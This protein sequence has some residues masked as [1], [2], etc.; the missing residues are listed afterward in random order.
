MSATVNN[1]KPIE[2]SECFKPDKA[3]EHR[4]LI[5][6]MNQWAFEMDEAFLMDASKQ[7]RE[8]ADRYDSASVLVRSWNQYHSQ[9]IHAEADAL[10]HLAKYI[11]A[12]KKVTELRKKEGDLNA[13]ADELSKMF[14]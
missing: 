12:N 7:L 8:K 6:L 2:P 9:T 4:M 3:Q 5:Q 13:R 11:Q 1:I 14:E 10:E